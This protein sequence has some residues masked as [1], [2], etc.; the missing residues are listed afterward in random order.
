M[1]IAAGILMIIAGVFTYTIMRAALG[2]GSW[3]GTLLICGLI[4]GGIAILRR[5]R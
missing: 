5:K 2:H 1:G 4:A 3:L